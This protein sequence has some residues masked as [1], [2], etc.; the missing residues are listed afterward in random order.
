[1]GFN[2]QFSSLQEVRQLKGLISFLAKQ[3]LNYPGYDNW[4]Q[5]TEYELDSGYKKAIMAFSD[6]KLVGDLV[7]P[8]E[9]LGF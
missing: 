4:V 6:G 1:M 8:Q 3:D 2:F 9:T 5:K 7:V